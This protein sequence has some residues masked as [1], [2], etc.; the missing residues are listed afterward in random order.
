MTAIRPIGTPTTGTV[1]Q[2]AAT[3]KRG[4]ATFAPLSATRSSR[5]S[6]S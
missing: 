4:D 3:E 1:R 6:L 5:I 2:S